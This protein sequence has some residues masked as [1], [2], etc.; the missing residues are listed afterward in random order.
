MT[1]NS[2]VG[3]DCPN[4]PGDVHL[5]Q[6][7]L[8][9]AGLYRGEVDGICGP[10]TIAAITEYQR[11]VLR[12]PDGRIDPGGVT[13]KRLVQQRLDTPPETSRDW[14][15]VLTESD[16]AEAAQLL[17]CEVAAI[18]AVAEVE[19]AG[20]GFLNNG[21]PRILFEGHW[22]YRHT[23]GAHASTHPALCHRTQTNDHYAKGS[24]EERGAGEW[25]RLEA[26]KHLNSHAALLSCSVGKFQVMGFNHKLC[27]FDTVEEFWQRLAQGERE[28]LRAFCGFVKSKGL[29]DHLVH[30]Q[31]DK[32]AEG[33]NGK[34]Y[35]KFS[36]DVKMA[37]AYAKFAGRTPSAQV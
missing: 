37:K 32:F 30:H 21:K 36:Y 6:Q 12:N 34:G 19:S 26:A 7:L 8:R 24:A 31:W 29:A 15:A 5:V 35:K 27:G 11:A 14:P 9:T 17:G 13:W 22:F 18:K 23:K 10:Q 3:K 28:Q 16:Y 33:Y 1:L 4:E 20:A 2:S 25:A